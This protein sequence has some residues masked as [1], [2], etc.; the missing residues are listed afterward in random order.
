MV[1]RWPNRCFGEREVGR[2][3]KNKCPTWH[4][5]KAGEGISRAGVPEARLPAGLQDNGAGPVFWTTSK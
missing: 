1:E 2:K 3:N 4:G 5:G